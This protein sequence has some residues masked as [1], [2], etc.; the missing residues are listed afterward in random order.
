[1]EGE[2]TPLEVEDGW[3]VN[4]PEAGFETVEVTELKLEGG[5]VATDCSP[6]SK[7]A[8]VYCV[9]S[10]VVVG[11]REA[12]VKDDVSPCCLAARLRFVVS[13]NM[14]KNGL[15]VSQTI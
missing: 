5:R 4:V 3:T 9:T 12:D 15:K 6:T 7:T 1:M 13:F 14:V 2:S 8:W 10:K 11:I